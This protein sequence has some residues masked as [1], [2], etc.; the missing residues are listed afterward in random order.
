[1][2]ASSFKNDTILSEIT[3]YEHIKYVNIKGQDH[4]IGLFDKAHINILPTFQK[5]GI[6]LKLINTLYNGRFCIVNTKMVEDTGLENVC[7][8]AETK[9]EFIKKIN[10][11]TA[12]DFT[13]KMTRQ[14]E[15][16]LNPFNIKTNAQKIIEL[17]Y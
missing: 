2:I 6:K 9:E 5:T 14:R 16:A 7:E 11:I 10:E 1:V 17:L 3:K 12:K 15:K 8:I 4:I 13:N